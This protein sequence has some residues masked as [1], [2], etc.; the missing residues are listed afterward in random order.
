M[1][2]FHEYTQIVLQE[3]PNEISATV[4]LSGCGRRCRGC[5]SPHYQDRNN[6]SF[7]FFD[8]IKD[9]CEKYKNKA[10]CILFFNGDMKDIDAMLDRI[11]YCRCMGF[12]V[13]L[14][15]GYE[16]EELDSRLVGMLDYIKT[17]SYK[18][19]LGGLDKKTTNQ[20]LWKR[21]D[22][23]LVDITAEMQRE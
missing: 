11:T 16:L 19:E 12:K 1:N 18:E 7:F 13:A 14:Y 4:V 9:I 15:S 5:H 20:R 17:G 3:I 8:D 22:G 23:E 2:Y 6:G 10:S 21:V